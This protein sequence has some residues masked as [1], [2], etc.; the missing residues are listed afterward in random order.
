MTFIYI[1]I[2][3]VF[4]PVIIVLG[5]KQ[6]NKKLNHLINIIRIRWKTEAVETE[7]LILQ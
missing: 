3:A 1:N 2:C 4:V 5:T 7:D 6:I